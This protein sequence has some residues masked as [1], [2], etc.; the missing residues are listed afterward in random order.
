MVPSTTAWR[1]LILSRNPASL[2]KRVGPRRLPLWLSPLG[3]PLGARWML[4]VGSGHSRA[5]LDLYRYF[6]LPQ[7]YQQLYTRQSALPSVRPE[8]GLETF[9]HLVDRALSPS[10]LLK[11]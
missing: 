8:E 10:L 9:Y 3:Q 6:F 2:L 1:I 7:V 5:A 4:L 11:A